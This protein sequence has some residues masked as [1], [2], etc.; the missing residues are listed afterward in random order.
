[1][2]KLILMSALA[3]LAVPSVATAQHHDRDYQSRDYHRY[4]RGDRHHGDRDRDRYRHPN[5]R[6]VAYVAPYRTWRYRPVTVGYQLQSVFFGPRYY[7]SDYSAFGLPYPGANRR[8]IRYGNDLLLVNVRTGRV[9]R[10]L[11]NRYYW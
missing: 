10:V 6:H 9:L 4:D 5:R 7:V 1:M 8:W 3:A 11:P 2:R